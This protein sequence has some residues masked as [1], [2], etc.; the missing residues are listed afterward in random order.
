[1]CATYNNE[2]A[3]ILYITINELEIIVRIMGETEPPNRA[4]CWIQTAGFSSY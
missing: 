1:V 3:N 4:G 2:E